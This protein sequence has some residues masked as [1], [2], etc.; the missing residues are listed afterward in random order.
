MAFQPHLK[1][2]N[3]HYIYT[4]NILIFRTHA[5]GSADSAVFLLTSG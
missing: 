1:I 4:D 3:Y 2:T 5:H